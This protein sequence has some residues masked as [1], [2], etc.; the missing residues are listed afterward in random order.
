MKSV[1]LWL[2]CCMLLGC[3]TNQSIIDGNQ[4]N[5]QKNPAEKFV[6]AYNEHNIELMLSLVHDDI[7][8][9]FVDSAQVY[10]E[11]KDKA[12]LATYLVPFF[13]QKP[14]AK[15]VVLTSLQHGPFIQQ[16]EQALWVDSQN[17]PQSQCSLSVY[18]IRHQLIINV[19]YLNA[20]S[21]D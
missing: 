17:Q 16:V 11:T 20:Y 3:H 2:F 7:K 5:E 4:Y 9:M 21:C 8:Y 10:T 12:A 1:G 19:W 6:A 13:A 18:E 15:S 14:N